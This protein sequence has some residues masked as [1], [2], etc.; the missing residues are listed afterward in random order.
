MPTA[1][2]QRTEQATS[3]RLKIPS[4]FHNE[5][6]GTNDTS[7]EFECPKYAIVATVGAPQ[8]RDINYRSI[9]LSIS[10][11]G[12]NPS[13]EPLLAPQ[14]GLEAL[15]YESETLHSPSERLVGAYVLYQQAELEAQQVDCILSPNSQRIAILQVKFDRAYPVEA[16]RAWATVGQP[17]TFPNDPV[18]DLQEELAHTLAEL[19]HA[20]GPRKQRT[21]A[22]A[23]EIMA[24]AGDSAE[25]IDFGLRSLIENRRSGRLDDAIDLLTEVEP[26]AVE[27]FTSWSADA[28]SPNGANDDYWYVL[29]R[30]AGRLGLSKLACRFL[31]SPFPAIQEATVEALADIG[32][33]QSLD[34]LKRIAQ[35][36]RRSK[37]IRDLAKQLVT[38]LS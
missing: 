33:S 28:F 21:R 7:Q 23:A 14:R 22:R 5:L 27:K 13:C 31:D 3:Q 8:G 18:L 2:E 34:A 29:I 36:N 9:W 11:E 16:P 32:D 38:D 26:S 10:G 25:I 6:A 30:V 1:V 19:G 15:L 4:L 20:V 24:R 12:A 35:D 17:T 37:F